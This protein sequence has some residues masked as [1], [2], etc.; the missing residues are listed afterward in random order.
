[1][2]S[3]LEVLFRQFAQGQTGC[4]TVILAENLPVWATLK[5]T[6]GTAY[7]IQLGELTKLNVLY[8]IV[9]FRFIQLWV[10]SGV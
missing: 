3:F 4:K 1:M 6:G 10:E 2:K 8:K 7:F 5:F 9:H